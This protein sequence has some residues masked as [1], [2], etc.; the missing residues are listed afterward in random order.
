[1]FNK[2]VIGILILLA[3]LISGLSAYTYML[4]QHIDT[5]SEQLNVSRE[6]QVNQMTVVTDELTA[7]RG[8]TLNLINN[9]GNNIDGVVIK[10][11][12]LRG[13]V[14]EI[15]FLQDEIEDVTTSLSQCVLNATRIYQDASQGIVRVTDGES[16]IG[17]G[18]IY[19]TDGHIITAYHVV[20]D[21]SE[22][23]VILPD[24]HTAPAAITG[25]SQASD[26]AILTLEG[27][28]ITIPLI[29]ADSAKILVGQPV[30]T[31]GNPFDLNA[32]LTSGVVSQ[33]NR[34]EEIGQYSQ[35]RW[36]ANLIQFDAAVNF[37]NSGCPLLNS[38]GEVIGMVIAR[39]DPSIGDGVYYAVSSN[40]LKRVATS[41]INQ[42]SFDYPWLG[43][44]LSNLTPQMIKSK[45]LDTINGVLVDNII[46]GSPAKAA[47]IDIGDIIIAMD[48]NA[49]VD[50]AE[51]TS[52]LGEYKSPGDEA[53]ITVIRGNT[54]LELSVTIGKLP[55]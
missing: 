17:T 48:G 15:Y 30:V 37:G 13:E 55:S 54:R 35:K 49:I 29:F 1:M 38:D 32:T 10:V 7:F 33:L 40:K 8:E 53:T 6:E 23:Y 4:S 36:V 51:L 43:V 47:G 50:I 34:Y 18:F 42:G 52:Y 12:S 45:G 5:L 24:G 16:L 25:S 46:A 19:D 28:P 20:E 3:F 27:E 14:D 41:L 22:I 44:S 2:V 9:L 39:V 31:I 11:D 26:I 21:L